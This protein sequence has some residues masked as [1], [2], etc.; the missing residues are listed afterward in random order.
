MEFQRVD[1]LE[2]GA[3]APYLAAQKLH[4]GDFSRG[5]LFM[6]NDALKPDYAFFENCLVLR[7]Y[8]AGKCFYH[9]PISLTHDREEE[10]A[11]ISALERECR[12]REVRLHFTN[13]PRDRIADMVPRYAEALVTNN[14][15][16][17]DYLYLAS[18]FCEY[19]GKS[20]AGQR[21]HVRK[22]EKLYPDWR[23]SEASPSDMGG[24]CEFLKEYEGIQRAK[25]GYLAE[26]EM[27]EVY[28][29]LPHLKE[30]AIFAGILTVGGKVVGFSAGERCGDMVVVHIEKALRGYEGIYPFL[31][32]QFARTFA[33]DARYLNRMDDAGDLGLRKSKLQYLP[34]E[35]VQK[36]NVTPK[37]A[38][39]L[40]GK[41]PV[42]EGERLTL[43]PVEREHMAEYA[44]LAGDDVRNRY[45]GY[46]WRED[47]ARRPSAAGFL[48]IAKESFRCRMEMPLGIFFE[49]KLCGEAV[50]HRF[51]YDASAEVGVRLLPEFE[52]RGIAREAVKM[53]T[54]Y[55][56][57]KLN[58]ERMEAKC[59]RENERSHRMLL[60]A[61]MRPTGSDDIYHY[62]LRTPEM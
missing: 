28:A 33:G 2:Q 35:L 54:E 5:F 41:L 59:F 57:S 58:I 23:F 27:D 55:A 25:G 31:A 1:K 11:A 32:Q 30:L 36:Y 49:G 42:I 44:R 34:V 46:D 43:A 19:P 48:R 17:R 6:W 20:H 51:G 16:W 15:R 38:I 4:M 29:I 26:E 18:D 47:H 56:F 37:R 12:D 24:V 53:Y 8:Y 7:E 3:L 52:G 22:F 21:N 61:G 14:R 62:F 39:D 50:L 45:W 40:V 10:L 9:F 13:V 60:A